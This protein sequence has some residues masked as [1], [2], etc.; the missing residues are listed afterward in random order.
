MQDLEDDMDE[1]IRKASKDYP[2]RLQEDA[3][4]FVAGKIESVSKEKYLSETAGVRAYDRKK[5]LLSLLAL[6]ITAFFFSVHE[7]HPREI[8]RNK[9][10]Y[11]SDLPAFAGERNAKQLGDLKKSKTTR[12]AQDFYQI[13]GFYEKTED[14]QGIAIHVSDVKYRKTRENIGREIIRQETVLPAFHP[15]RL[16]FLTACSQELAKTDLHKKKTWFYLG[17]TA[18]PQF[19]EVRDQGLSSPGWSMGL[20]AGLRLSNKLSLETG[21]N[22]SVK[23]YHTSGKYFNLQKI[24]GAMPQGMELIS[25]QGKSNVLEVPLMLK[26]DVMAV[27]KGRIFV[28]AGISSYI[29]TKEANEYLAVVNGTRQNMSGNYTKS[30][31]YYTAS[32][33]FSAGYEYHTGN[34]INVRVAPYLQIPMANFGVGSLPILSTGI[35]LGISI[36][37]IKK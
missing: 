6:L 33:N 11:K 23:Q 13:G 2:F 4:D 35:N 21:I 9:N 26:Y 16:E 32:A 20:L 17:V 5:I 19:S 25:M 8:Q 3:W 27:K 18:G 15:L 7:M 22:F 37:V 14:S 36:P 29:L 24:S 31:N 1:L 30:S 12:R 34:G 10:G 28:S